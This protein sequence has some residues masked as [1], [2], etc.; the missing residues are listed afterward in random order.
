MLGGTSYS[1]VINF[2][3]QS[4]YLMNLRIKFRMPLACIVSLCEFHHDLCYKGYVIINVNDQIYYL[5]NRAN[6]RPRSGYYQIYFLYEITLRET[7]T[8]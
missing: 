6:V 2:K 7:I 4:H 3:K 5:R 8:Y 1:F